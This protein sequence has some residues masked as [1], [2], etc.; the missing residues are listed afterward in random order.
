MEA[1]LDAIKI[2]DNSEGIWQTNHY[3][4]TEIK[5][6]TEDHLTSADILMMRMFMN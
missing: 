6:A 4:K 1:E 5:K 2:K 3:P